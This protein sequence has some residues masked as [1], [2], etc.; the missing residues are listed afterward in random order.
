MPELISAR[1]RDD[2][3]VRLVFVS[4]QKSELFHLRTLLL[5]IPAYSYKELRTVN[6]ITYYTFQGTATTFGLFVDIADAEL[7]LQEAI[8]QYYAPY[9]LGFLY[10]QLIV[11]IPAPALDLWNK[12]KDE[13]SADHVQRFPD[14]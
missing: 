10:A 3:V 2:S 6:S 5:H 13:L 1:I 7:C 12:N 9:H 4:L 11:D 8:S 14:I